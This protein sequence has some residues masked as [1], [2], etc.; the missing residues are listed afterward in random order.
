MLTSTNSNKNATASVLFPWK[1]CVIFLW[2]ISDICF[3]VVWS[4]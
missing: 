3:S 1:Q 2:L 4:Y